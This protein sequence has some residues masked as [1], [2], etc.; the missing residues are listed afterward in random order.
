M[1]QHIRL[2]AHMLPHQR[3]Q[4][5][6][7][8]LLVVQRPLPL[9]GLS[10]DGSL[11]T[12]LTVQAFAAV[13]TNEF[14]SGLSS[15]QLALLLPSWLVPPAVAASLEAAASARPSDSSAAGSM[16]AP[17]R[18]QWPPSPLGTLR[19]LDQHSEAAAALATCAPAAG[20]FGKKLALPGAC[21]ICHIVLPAAA[22]SSDAGSATASHLLLLFALEHVL[23]LL[24]VLV[25]RAIP[26]QRP[27]TQRPDVAEG[28]RGITVQQ[29]SQAAT[30]SAAAP[31][32]PRGVPLQPVKVHLNPLF[33]VSTARQH[34][35]GS[36]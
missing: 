36:A 32:A 10:L 35:G 18:Q 5:C 24:M 34:E 11:T 28:R 20:P 6:M 30:V 2:T 21:A 19:A 17:G 25:M 29:D 7:K 16:G 3:T 9:R 13:L 22:A 15:G 12:V 26:G 8:L 23:V 27:L 33:A 1:Q 4:D 31:L 14:L